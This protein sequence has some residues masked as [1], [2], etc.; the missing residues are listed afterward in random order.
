LAFWVA[1]SSTVLKHLNSK[2]KIMLTKKR[3]TIWIF[4][5]LLVLGMLLLSACSGAQTPT[6][7]PMDDPQV[8]ESTEVPEV[9]EPTEAVPAP[10]DVAAPTDTAVPDDTEPDTGS[11]D[12]VS[13][14]DDVMPIFQSRCIKCHGGERTEKKFDMT[15]YDKLMAG[16]EKGAVL[17]AGDAAASKML[18]LIE[19]G[20]MPKRSAKLLP[21][22]IQLIIDWIN[23]GAQNN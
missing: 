8:S 16:S 17:V 18:Q 12:L 7:D 3:K 23:Q 1:L 5:A 21:D 14:K 9:D 11:G 20:K 19:Q 22:Q 2:G 10:T 15:S 13:F 6:V 4:P